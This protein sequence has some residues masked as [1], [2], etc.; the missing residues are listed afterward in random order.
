MLMTFPASI[1]FLVALLV[2]GVGRNPLAYTHKPHDLVALLV[3][4]VG[5]NI[6]KKQSVKVRVG[7]PPRGGRG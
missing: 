1:C 3:E 2:E 6:D 4:G 5:R 7:R